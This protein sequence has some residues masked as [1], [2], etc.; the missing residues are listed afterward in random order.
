MGAPPFS[1][2]G[3]FGVQKGPEARYSPLG[4]GKAIHAAE[5][6]FLAAVSRRPP[7]RHRLTWR[8]PITLPLF[9][10]AVMLPHFDP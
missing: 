7:R 9:R 1:Y 8:Q 4:R 5:Y 3:L 6:P 10:A 2:S